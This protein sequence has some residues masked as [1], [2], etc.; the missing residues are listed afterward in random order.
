MNTI[1]QIATVAELQRNYRP[2]INRLKKSG[3]PLFVLKNGKPDIV[4][5][6]ASAFQA[7]IQ[8]HKALEEDYLLSLENEALNESKQGKTVILKDGQTLMDIINSDAN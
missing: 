1:P 3:Q 5:I 7:Q 4:I 8:A 2:L 6:E